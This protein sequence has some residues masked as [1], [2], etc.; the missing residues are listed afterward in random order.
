MMQ[1]SVTIKCSAC[2][3]EVEGVRGADFTGG[4][5]D[6]SKGF[7]KN[8]ARP[9]EKRL[10]DNCM[11]S[12]PEFQ[13]VYGVQSGVQDS[14]DTPRGRLVAARMKGIIAKRDRM[15]KDNGTAQIFG[16]GVHTPVKIEAK[17]EQE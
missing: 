10:C 11:W 15:L 9:G 8:F 3:K 14:R 1:Y 2:K 4:F 6:V 13:F 5:Y 7:W 16:R 17:R 12:R